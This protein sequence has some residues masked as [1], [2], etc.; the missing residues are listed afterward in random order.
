MV[1]VRGSSC[2]KL[3]RSFICKATRNC[4]RNCVL[5]RLDMCLDDL[6]SLKIRKNFN[7][8]IKILFYFIFRLK[9]KRLNLRF[10]TYIHHSI[11]MLKKYCLYLVNAGSGTYLFFWVLAECR[12]LVG[13]KDAARKLLE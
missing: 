7:N 12:I 4:R 3:N 5:R 10:N 1:I 11:L 13:N 9:N 8:R 2:E 6:V